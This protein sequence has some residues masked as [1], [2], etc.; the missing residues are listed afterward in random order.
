[1]P[2]MLYLLFVIVMI[3]AV[4]A[5]CTKSEPKENEQQIFK[6][7]EQSLKEKGVPLSFVSKQESP[8]ILEGVVPNVYKV[9][10]I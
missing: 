5:G 1:M 4:L 9:D 6:R 7:I 2:K 10:S 3:P 8:T